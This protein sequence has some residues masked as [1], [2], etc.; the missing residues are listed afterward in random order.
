MLGDVDIIAAGL[1]K[2]DE[3]DAKG[4]NESNEADAIRDSLDAPWHRL[5]REEQEFFRKIQIKNEQEC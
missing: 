5:S 4:Q 3:L 2:L 1:A